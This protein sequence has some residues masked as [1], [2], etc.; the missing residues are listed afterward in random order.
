MNSVKITE[1]TLKL[2]NIKQILEFIMNLV[3]NLNSFQALLD[4]TL[5]IYIITKNVPII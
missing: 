3:N 5:F 1:L 4:Y 2:T